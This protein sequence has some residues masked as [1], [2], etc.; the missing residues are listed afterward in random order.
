MQFNSLYFV[1]FFLPLTLAGY[2]GLAGRGHRA[3]ADWWVILAS[4][5]FYGATNL[6][7]PLMLG[8][9]LV[10]NWGLACQIERAE[11]NA[12]RGTEQG[13]G[14]STEKS[15]GSGTEQG[16]GA[17]FWAVLGIVLNTAFLGIFKYT[18]FF[19]E[20]L[21][22]LLQQDWPA[23]NLILPLGISFI[24]FSQISFLADVRRG[25]VPMTGESGVTFREYVLF[26][27]FFPK[28][29]QGPISTMREFLPEL[30]K[31]ERHRFS[32]KGMVVGIQM[33]TCGLFKKVIL[34]DSLGSMVTQYYTQF[35]YRSNI[36]SLLVML[37]YTFQIYLDFSGYSDM[38]I[39]ISEMLGIHL[40]PNFD[41]PYKAASVTDFWRRWHMSLTSFL[42][43]YI[44]FPLGG[45]KRGA[46]R[47]YLNIMIVYLISGLWHGA[48]WTFILWGF[49]H[50]AAQIIE[51]LL[52]KAYRKV[53]LPVRWC[54]TFG[55]VN[56]LWM[57]FR[58]SS[59]AEF[60]RFWW[61]LWV[62]K[63]WYYSQ[64]LASCLHISGVRTALSVLRL[65][66]SDQ[67]VGAVSTAI[68]LGGCLGLC[69][70][71]PNNQK[72]S[73]KI[74]RKSLIVTAAMLF[75]CMLSMSGMSTFIYN[76]F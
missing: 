33:F 5:L 20:N 62:D 75:W 17:G 42:R 39:G 4:F 57:L 51:R 18:N 65:P 2:Y 38:A 50:G 10:M 52:G 58:S 48:N 71:A 21:N 45:S 37:A 28:L 61:H 34:A 35:T 30:R 53:W 60:Q 68:F 59:A 46:I 76:D 24:I 73:Y 72:R 11:K 14:E 49:F 31:K 27:V 66:A 74:T 63:S 36:D 44:Y 41:S 12:G 54:I 15:T 26:S 29:T 3:T 40:Q 25:T 13:I 70:L 67:M 32:S 47:T 1:I 7:Y 19:L 43:E 69:L 16:I 64:D 22:V 56:I 8:I 6:W 55:I 23:V 9:L